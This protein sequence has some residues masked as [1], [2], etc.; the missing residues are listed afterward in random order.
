MVMRRDPSLSKLCAKAR[1]QVPRNHR[2]VVTRRCLVTV[3]LVNRGQCF[4]WR[5]REVFDV[6][7]PRGLFSLFGNA[8]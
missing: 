1:Q 5:V 7:P 2:G 8:G 4:G 6:A 3:Q